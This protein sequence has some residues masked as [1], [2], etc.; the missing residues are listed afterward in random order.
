MKQI[1]IV[2]A[3]ATLVAQ[4]QAGICSIY[5]ERI[6]FEELTDT[7]K[8]I[9]LCVTDKLALLDY[10]PSQNFDVEEIQ[11]QYYDAKFQ[12]FG[13]VKNP[14]QELKDLFQ[15]FKNYYEAKFDTSINIVSLEN[16]KKG[17]DRS[18]WGDEELKQKIDDEIKQRSEPTNVALVIF[19]VVVFIAILS[20]LIAI[21]VS[22]Y[23]IYVTNQQNALGVTNT[24][25][26]SS[27]SYRQQ[28]DAN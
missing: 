2:F 3:L 14:T 25:F 11:K 22:K 4:T 1:L 15:C 27:A 5:Q 10:L 13:K 16:Q 6:P 20:L 21:A 7:F 23:R 9:L 17:T 26:G 24:E 28:Q 8:Q 19:C 12:C 18:N